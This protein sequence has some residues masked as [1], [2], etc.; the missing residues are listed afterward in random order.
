MLQPSSSCSALFMK[1]AEQEHCSLLGYQQDN[2]TYESILCK[3]SPTLCSLCM[4]RKRRQHKVQACAQ[5]RSI[6][7]LPERS[8][9]DLNDGDE[10]DN[11]SQQ[12]SADQV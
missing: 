9:N 5:S 3:A 8:S 1:T 4:P 12:A 2:S 10:D 7:T 11:D 6:R